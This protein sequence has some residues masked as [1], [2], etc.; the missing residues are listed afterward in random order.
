MSTFQIKELYGSF[1]L[2]PIEPTEVLLTVPTPSALQSNNV[3]NVYINCDTTNGNLILVLPK[4]SSLAGLNTKIFITTPSTGEFGLGTTALKNQ[5]YVVGYYDMLNPIYDSIN[6][7]Y[8]V[9]I[10]T[11]NSVTEISIGS[12]NKWV[13]TVVPETVNTPVYDIYPYIITPNLIKTQNEL[14]SF[15][16]F[17]FYGLGFTGYK[18]SGTIELSNDT[19]YS[20]Y[21][22]SIE[23]ENFNYGDFLPSKI[24]GVVTAYDGVSYIQNALGYTIELV[25][26]TSTLV[27]T[28][29]EVIADPYSYVNGDGITISGLDIIINVFP[30]GLSTGNITGVISYEY[31]FLMPLGSTPTFIL[32]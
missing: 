18:M 5:I 6:G 13:A 4:I 14:S 7:Q 32:Y 31:D 11:P 24:S 22:G 19:D 25:D 8:V 15:T 20:I 29:F 30:L 17:G 9:T 3:N 1:T 28:A 16:G 2:A 12:N 27:Q 26:S 21:V 10:G 23:T